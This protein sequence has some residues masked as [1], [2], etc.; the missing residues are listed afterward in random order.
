MG[1]ALPKRPRTTQCGNH[2]ISAV[3]LQSDGSCFTQSI[4]LRHKGFFVD[5]HTHTHHADRKRWPKK[6]QEK[7]QDKN[8]NFLA[9]QKSIR[10]ARR[11]GSQK[12]KNSQKATIKCGIN[13]KKVSKYFSDDSEEDDND[14]A[15][16]LS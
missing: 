15:Q 5:T 2:G 16:S 9:L 3:S 1:R 7:G 12:S 6:C 14:D 13:A 8:P 11:S 10:D 4:N